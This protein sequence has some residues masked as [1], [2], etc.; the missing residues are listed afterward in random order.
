MPTPGYASFS[1]AIL[2][3]R[4]V[5][6][7]FPTEVDRGGAWDLE[8]I[9]GLCGARTRAILFSHPNNPT[10]EV[11]KPGFLA[12]L[13]ALAHEKS[14][15]LLSDE[16]YR[17]FVWGAQTFVS[18]WDLPG[19]RE[20]TVRITSFSKSFGVTGWRVGVLFAK[21]ELLRRVLAVHDTC[22]TCAP[23]VSQHL[24]LLLHRERDVLLLANR[25][26]L[27]GRVKSATDRL[28]GTER[29]SEISFPES[30]YYLFPRSP[31]GFSGEEFCDELFVSSSV[32]LVPGSAFGEIAVRNVRLSLAGSDEIVNEGVRR[33]AVVRSFG[34]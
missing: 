29:F 27:F 3:A 33:L 10:G 31:D 21:Q 6:V 12:E 24:A 11:L 5:P 17:D 14:L 2:T 9:R 25:R 1:R 30:G 18:P 22:V 20:V 4:G 8:R 23:V 7:I 19:G 32:A 28:A 34:E 26:I 13:I 16:T 15:V